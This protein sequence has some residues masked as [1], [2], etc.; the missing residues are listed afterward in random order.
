MNS[1]KVVSMFK[2]GEGCQVYP[3]VG[4]DFHGYQQ[5][6]AIIRRLHY[7]PLLAFMVVSDHHEPRI[8]LGDR[9]LTRIQVT[10]TSN[11]GFVPFLL[12]KMIW[13]HHGLRN[14]H[15]LWEIFILSHQCRTSCFIH[16][17]QPDLPKNEHN[18][19]RP[20]PRKLRGSG[21]TPIWF[22]SFVPVD[23]T[24]RPSKR[25]CQPMVGDRAARGSH[26]HVVRIGHASVR[27]LAC[28]FHY[29]GFGYTC[30]SGNA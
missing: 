25:Q 21:A 17:S 8:L 27:H 10:G 1:I 6:F 26:R 20:W 2:T 14:C 22:G 4:W 18:F 3:V 15:T 13:T 28:L 19:C 9:T 29:L 16:R 7:Q 24:S 5:I 12:K 30:W 11:D 23:V